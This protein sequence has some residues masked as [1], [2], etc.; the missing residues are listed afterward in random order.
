MPNS[1]VVSHITAPALYFSGNECRLLLRIEK[2]LVKSESS[3]K[4]HS[5]FD[6]VNTD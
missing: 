3:T 2:I 6:F 1:Q 4:A 5:Q